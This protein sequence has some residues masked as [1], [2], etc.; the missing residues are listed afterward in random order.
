MMHMI[1]TLLAKIMKLCKWCLI[2]L[3]ASMSILTFD[4]P[5]GSIHVH[6]DFC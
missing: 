2:L 5:A 1:D 6:S 3:G 4:D